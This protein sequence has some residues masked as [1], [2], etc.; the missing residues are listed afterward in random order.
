MGSLCVL[1]IA[2]DV[3][4]GVCASEG[5][6]SRD[7]DTGVRASECLRSRVTIA[8]DEGNGVCA[9]EGMSCF[10]D[11]GVEHI[12]YSFRLE[13]SPR[14]ELTR[15]ELPGIRITFDVRTFPNSFFFR[16]TVLSNS[17]W[18][19]NLIDNILVVCVN[20]TTVHPELL[21]QE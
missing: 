21:G 12:V 14:V 10:F 13:L 18:C 19:A 11:V 6:R 8:C 16:A 7:E 1:V 3:D 5:L 4:N 9:S 2:C 20:I 17:L 15:V